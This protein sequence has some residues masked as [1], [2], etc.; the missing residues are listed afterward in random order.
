MYNCKHCNYQTDNKPNYTRHLKTKRHLLKIEISTNNIPVNTN[1][2]IISTNN[3]YTCRYCN[4]QYSNLSS[5]NRHLK[6]CV[7]KIISDK[8]KLLF[9]KD[10]LLEDKTKQ[11]KIMKETSDKQFELIKET[12]DKLMSKFKQ[13]YE[14]E[15][16][17]LK[18]ENTALNNKLHSVKDA[19]LTV[20]QN[21]LKPANNN[22]TQI[23]IHN[24]PNAPNLSFPDNIKVDES[25]KEYVQLGGIKGLGKFISDYW[26]KDISP[27]NRSIWMVD[28]AR[29]KFLIRCKDAWVIDIDG[30]QFQEINLEKIQKIFN[31]YLQK[32]KFDRYDYI[33]TME[34]ILDIQTKNMIIKGLK[35]AGKYLVYDKEKFTDFDKIENE[36]VIESTI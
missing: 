36:E 31:E 4:Y 8:N 24:Y 28:S 30:T 17:Q 21:N 16:K 23:I 34:F 13:S 19:Q 32:Y 12:T 6:K 22:N 10:K 7:Q 27:P 33:K 35:D 18:L 29:N 25:L 2:Q 9:E 11:F 26:C 20:L 14:D 1:N 3:Q 15:I 5:L